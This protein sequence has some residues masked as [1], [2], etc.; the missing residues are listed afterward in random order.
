MFD[1]GC[2]VMIDSVIVRLVIT[3]EPLDE[4]SNDNQSDINGVILDPDPDII[5]TY[6]NWMLIKQVIAL[7]DPVSVMEGRDVLVTYSQ[8][9][10]NLLLCNNCRQTK[11]QLPQQL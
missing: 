2:V 7:R 10:V 4:A 3:K 5:P 11:I 1:D 6:T 8:S 9:V